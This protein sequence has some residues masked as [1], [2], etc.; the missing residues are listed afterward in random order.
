[1]M[2]VKASV[3]SYSFPDSRLCLLSQQIPPLKSVRIHLIAPDGNFFPLP[4]RVYDF[5]KGSTAAPVFKR[6]SG[7]SVAD[8][9]N[10][11]PV[12]LAQGITQ[13]IAH[14]LDDHQQAFS[15]WKRFGDAVWKLLLYPVNGILCHIAIIVLAQ[16]SVGD[17]RRSAP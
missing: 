8:D 13:E 5:F 12:V 17:D 4:G 3:A 2:K 1:M 6:V 10:R 14:S 11:F 16:A 7:G 15:V 9:D